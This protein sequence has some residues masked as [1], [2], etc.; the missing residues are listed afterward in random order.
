L[1]INFSQQLPRLD[2]LPQLHVPDHQLA[3]HPETQAGLNPRFHLASVFGG[4]NH[5]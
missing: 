3:T 5:D 2:T 4:V 1:G